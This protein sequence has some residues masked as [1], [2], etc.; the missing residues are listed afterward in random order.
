MVQL[1]LDEGANI[2]AVDN[3]KPTPLS[4]AA[5]PVWNARVVQLLL[6]KGA[7]PLATDCQGHTAL[8]AAARTAQ[9]T[10]ILLN[11]FFRRVSKPTG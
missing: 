6:E 11:Y 9:E 3:F 1:L 8:I 5:V 2:E 7:N 10:L 4:V